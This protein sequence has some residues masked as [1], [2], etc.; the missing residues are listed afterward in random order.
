VRDQ[1]GRASIQL[2]VDTYGHLV[3]GANRQ[4]VDRLDDAMERAPRT[5]GKEDVISP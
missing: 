4:A 5:T 3:L 2:T 1:L